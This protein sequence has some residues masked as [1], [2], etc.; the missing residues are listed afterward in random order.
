[1]G[2]RRV[3][4]DFYAK[5]DDGTACTDAVVSAYLAGTTTPT[6]MYSD[7]DGTSSLGS[8][9]A[10]LTTGYPPDLWMSDQESVKLVI[11]GTGMTTLTRDYYALADSSAT[12]SGESASEFKNFLSNPGFAAW[13]AGTSFS[14]ISGSGT[15]VETADGWY[16]SQSTAA[17][18]AVSRQTA[19]KTGARYGMR[20]G[21]PAA[22]SSTN[23]LRLWKTILT[24]DAYRLAGQT[25]TISFSVQA[26]ANFSA[27]SSLLSVILATGTSEGQSGDLIA[28]SGWGGHVNAVNQNQI[29]STTQTRYQFTATLNTGIKE[30]GVQLAYTPSGTA[31]ANDWVQI[32]DVQVEIA[33][34][35]TDMHAAPE[36]V[37]FVRGKLS[38]GGRL[39]AATAFTDPNADRIFGWDDSAS[40]FIGFTLP[41]G[42]STSGTAITFGTALT[43]YVADPLSAAELASITGTFGTAAFVADSSLVHISGTETITGAK[44][45][46]ALS[47]HKYSSTATGAD[48]TGSATTNVGHRIGASNVGSSGYGID[49]GV[50]NSDGTTWIQARDW[51]NYATNATLR[52]QPNGGTVTRGGNLMYDAGN[53]PGTA[54]TWT[55]N[56]TISKDDPVLYLIDSTVGGA[57]LFYTNESNVHKW[58]RTGVAYDLTLSS[59]ALTVSSADT[60][61]ASAVAPTSIYS[62]GYRGTPVVSG[63]SAYAFPT[64]DA[65]CTIYHDEASARTWTIPANASVAHVV[66]T[67]FVL[68]NTGNAGA[69]GAITLA[70]TTDTLRRG[71]GTS[72]TGSRTIS[73]GQVATIRKVT[74]T[75]WVITGGFT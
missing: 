18:N 55:A 52:L 40:D 12:D 47:Q 38:T 5:K 73:A 65:G 42:M 6:T 22:S 4:E 8:S 71:D 31:G 3:L 7:K 50:S 60:V 33:S 11:T 59:T 35:A 72:G 67:T 61:L 58:G 15:G 69:A 34:A 70:I 57:G 48:A 30:V 20:F 16:F 27:A 29:I 75:I 62:A 64:T 36:P 56:Q 46:S 54:I 23:Q 43:N 53:L 49:I 10:F 26:G 1:M 68:D 14:N 41:T 63:N 66:G 25:V 13:T 45:F 19:T 39:L 21:R 9:E 51:S 24:D 28:S 37:D 74:S 32:E 2:Y 44:T 17:S